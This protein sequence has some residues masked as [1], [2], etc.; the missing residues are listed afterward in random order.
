MLPTRIIPCTGE[1]LPVYGMGSWKT[2]DVPAGPERERMRPVLDGFF[3]AGGSVVDSSPMYGRAE[4][5]LGE[6]LPPPGSAPAFIATKVWTQGRERGLAQMEE[7]FRRLRRPILDLLQ[8]HNL[9]DWREHV[10]RLKE[11]KAAGR[12]RYWG[13]THYHAGAHA[14]LERV[15]AATRPDFIQINY[16]LEEPEAAERVLPFA[17]ANG[18]A[19]LANRPF[20]EG[21]LFR[22]V[23]GRE[24]P[25]AARA[26]G[27]ATW[28]ALFLD[29]VLGHP[30]VTCVIPAT[31]SAAHLA[32]NL[33]AAS[34]H[35]VPESVRRDWARSI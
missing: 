4:E 7:S 34:R 5:A 28:S 10:P 27:L 12:I 13:L 19:V 15:A 20:G 31:G 33:A 32:E 30:A 18:I 8:V 26:A 29:F 14:E 6:I 22:K 11:W 1:R 17:A 24:L 25:G 21:A 3:A 2:F 16:S 35:P 23:S 9:V